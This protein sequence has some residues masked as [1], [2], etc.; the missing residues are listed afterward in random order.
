M[1]KLAAITLFALPFAYTLIATI[2]SHIANRR[3]QR[4]KQRFEELQRRTAYV[5]NIEA[6]WED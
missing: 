3:Y 6:R 4:I 2:A 5:R 1:L